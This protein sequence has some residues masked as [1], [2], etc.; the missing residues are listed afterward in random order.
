MYKIGFIALFLF[1]GLTSYA[2]QY[3]F[4]FAEVEYNRMDEQL[5][6]TLIFS[7]HDLEDVLLKKKIISV[8]FDK[9]DH[10]P[11]TLAAI[12]QEI[13]QGFK[14]FQDGKALVRKTQLQTEQHGE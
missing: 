2:H 8:K 5:Q 4:A 3:Y 10:K 14:C 11:E 9:L 6:G 7:A 12:G 13:F 1:F